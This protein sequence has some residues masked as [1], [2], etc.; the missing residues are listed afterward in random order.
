MRRVCLTVKAIFRQSFLQLR[1][2]YQLNLCSRVHC[3]ATTF[4]SFFFFFYSFTFLLPLFSKFSLA[5]TFPLL[6]SQCATASPVIFSKRGFASYSFMRGETFL[7]LYLNAASIVW[8]FVK[9]RVCGFPLLT[10]AL[11][12]AKRA[13]R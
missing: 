2:H 7:L 3:H 11:Q 10:W 6:F 12:L 9:E 4:F 1:I 5:K 13:M 8:D